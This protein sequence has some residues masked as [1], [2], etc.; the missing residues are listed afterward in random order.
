[1]Q[2]PQASTIPTEQGVAPQAQPPLGSS[3]AHA[4]DE[5]FF[6][7]I[8]RHSANIGTYLMWVAV[9]I[10]GGVIA[11]LLLFIE[12]LRGQPLWLLSLIGTPMLLWSYLQHI[13]TRYKVSRRRVE[14]Q[15]GVITRR[16]DSLELWRVLDV[17]YEQSVLDR[18][19]DNAKITLI[20]TDQTHPNLLLYGLPDHRQLFER[21]RE[22]VQHARATG[23]PMELAPGH[24][25]ELFN[26]MHNH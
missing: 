26:Q 20:G 9:C 7:G 8:A 15:R 6:E 3:P 21:L 5:V 1:M 18:V 19:F 23:R 24:E 14:F 4:T 16:L 22:A 25:G 10:V 12:P 17:R 13:T 11:Y 2:E